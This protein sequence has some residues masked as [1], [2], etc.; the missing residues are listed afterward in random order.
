MCVTKRAW[1]FGK[2]EKEKIRMIRKGELVIE[3]LTGRKKAG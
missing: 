3:L 2:K 1:W